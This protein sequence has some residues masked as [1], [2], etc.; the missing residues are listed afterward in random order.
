MLAK[1]EMTI[2]AT[3]RPFLLLL[4]PAI[5]VVSITGSI[6]LNIFWHEVQFVNE[7]LHSTLETFGGIAAVLMALL[8][9]RLDQNNS[10]EKGDYYLLSMG[11]YTMGVLDI[12]H[13]VSTFGHGFIL[14]RSLA[15]IFGSIWFSLVWLS[16]INWHLFNEKRISLITVI[17]SFVLGLSILRFR[18]YFP[19]MILDGNFTIFAITINISSGFLTII[20]A[21]YFFIIFL[22]TSKTDA[23]L[24]T[25]MLL[26]LGLSALEFPISV[27]WNYDWW[28]W[29]VQRCLAYLVV[30]YYILRTFLRVCDEIKR[31]K[32]LLEIRIIERTAELSREVAERKLYGKQRDEVI[33]ELQAAHA[34]I[35][36]LTGFL[37]TCSSCK[38][39]RDGEDKWVQMESY[40]QNHSNAVFSHGICPECAKK[41]YPDIYEKIIKKPSNSKP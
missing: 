38:K 33:A 18:E 6:S 25:C 23:Y 1:H 29:H 37:P 34:H 22:H 12:C 31:S 39:I 10:K 20:S 30:F 3:K 36:V 7:R 21:F 40:I 13:S 8:L 2:A 41:L 4:L 27:A 32:E 9:L 19:A 35:K 11:F 5:L 15:G 16:S 17:F 26:L 14:L 28:F 24:F